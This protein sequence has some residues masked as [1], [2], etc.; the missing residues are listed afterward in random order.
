MAASFAPLRRN[1]SNTAT[2]SAAPSTGSVP[3]PNSSIKISVR[4]SASRSIE[5]I[6]VMCAENVDSD[7]SILCSSPMS[8]S[9]F[10]NTDT[11]E[12]SDAGI[13]NPH[14]AIS[15]KS[16]SVLIDT[17]LPPVFGPVITSESKS[18]PKRISIGTAVFIF[19]SGCRAFFSSISPI[20]F[21]TGLLAFILYAKFALEN[22]RFNSAA[23]A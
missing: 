17:V 10:P 16:P 19:K 11:R 22:I 21:K 5:T 7:C 1:A 9:T 14:A 4:S 23:L 18:V 3:A 6:F 2:A 15:V 8:A 13:Y 20:A 12:L